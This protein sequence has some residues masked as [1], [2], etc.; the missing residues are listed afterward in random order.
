MYGIKWLKS[1]DVDTY[2]KKDPKTGED[3]TSI[4]VDMVFAFNSP[5]A[6]VIAWDTLETRK[7]IRGLRWDVSIYYQM[8]QNSK[9]IIEVWDG[10]R[11]YEIVLEVSLDENRMVKLSKV[12]CNYDDEVFK[13]DERIKEIS[14]IIYRAKSLISLN[15]WFLSGKDLL[16]KKSG[17][18]LSKEEKQEIR[19]DIEKTNFLLKS[20]KWEELKIHLDN[21]EQAAFLIF[22]QINQPPQSENESEIISN[23]K[24][25]N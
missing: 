24:R 20:E 11:K 5:N 9:K 10:V 6:K 17:Y 7:S 25:K 12:T 3:K 13:Y 22:L 14:E 15:K 8:V 2:S 1:V 4:G 21:L 16:G 23:F 18:S 19:N